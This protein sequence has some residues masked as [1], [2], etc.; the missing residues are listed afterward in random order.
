MV[1]RTFA[2]IKPD[3]VAA[4]KTG[5][6]ISLIELNKFKIVHIEK[7]Q[8]TVEQAELFYRVHQNQP[9]FGEL[10][11]YMISG[12]VV[13]MM[14]EKPNAIKE[15]RELMGATNPA[16]AEVGTLR[17]MFGTSIGN[18]AVHGSDSPETA[19]KELEFFFS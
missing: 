11:E 16:K 1:E 4:L 18:N 8:L 9:F 13:V 2:I 7:K 14:L 19:A 10:V 5:A 15:W 12:P 3:A 6:I 17:Y